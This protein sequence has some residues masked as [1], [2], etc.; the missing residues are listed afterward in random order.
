MTSNWTKQ[1]ARD[2]YHTPYW[3]DGYFD[4][5]D[6]G[7]V[8]AHPQGET[9]TAVIDLYA[10]A[11]TMKADGYSFP[12]LVRLVDVLHHR[13]AALNKAFNQAIAH[14]GY[15]ADYLSVYPIKV[16][17]QKTVVQHILENGAYGVGLETG[18]K[19]ELLAT[20]GIAQEHI[21][22]IICNGY[23]DREYVRLALLGQC[24]GHRVCIILE[25]MNE[26]DY[27]L[28][29]AMAFGADI[30][31]GVR[32][33]PAAIGTGKWQDSVG[34]KS[35][36]GLSVSQLLTVVERLRQ[37]G[38]LHWLQVVHYHLGSQ[39]NSID[40]ICSGVQEGMRYYQ[41]LY[42]L[43]APIHTLDI[44]G[45]LGVDYEGTRSRSDF[46]V[47]YRLEEYAD[48]VIDAAKFFA[49]ASLLPHPRIITESGR[50]MTAHHAVLIT[51]VISVE[52]P[53]ETQAQLVLDESHHRYL[54]RFHE[55]QSQMG[56]QNAIQRYQE[57]TKLFEDSHQA[58][59][60][61]EMDLIQRAEIDRLY[62]GCCEQL[63]SVLTLA[64]RSHRE[65]LDC[66]NEK[67]AHKLVC[68]FSLFQSLP[69]SW[70]LDQIFPILPL[71]G[72][73]QAPGVHAVLHDITCDSD[74]KIDRYA[75]HQGLES[76]L[77]L[78]QPEHSSP[79]LLGIFLVGAY[80]EIL[81][82]LH[83]LFADTNVV[84]IKLK[85][86]GGYEVIGA[87]HG[88]STAS[89]LQQMNFDD[90]FLKKSYANQLAKQPLA[91]HL[92]N[93]YFDDLVRGLTGYTYF[94]ELSA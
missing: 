18:S 74:G 54:K 42:E 11:Q 63:M 8:V 59:I 44:G 57:A 3:G 52:S 34:E 2:L 89:A 37:A 21:S 27:I 56:Q 30:C 33:R 80:Q 26:L 7:T 41:A 24:M 10:L 19:A 50:A 81:G 85:A 28:E 88:E 36:F 31:L 43:G 84:E 58:Y 87:H 69:D 94:E 14:H 62:Y 92:K 16:N 68:N 38:K 71:S 70:A 17:Q 12:L 61:G 39:M 65:L 22:L 5:S 6:E 72:L 76:T 48:R 83:N 91:D 77:S 90:E 9:Q 13:V 51:D 46:S 93:S 49:D 73:N 66:L 53:P 23:K 75:N 1:S 55:L 32:I 40:D 79:L 67:L 15:Q 29:E 20:L 45:G 86:E 35:K 78:P 60:R 64:V 82:D 4:I 47:N 25:K